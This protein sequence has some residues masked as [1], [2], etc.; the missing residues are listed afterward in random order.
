[1]SFCALAHAEPLA[2]SVSQ[3]NLPG[4]GQYGK[5][6]LFA[7]ALSNWLGSHGQSSQLIYYTYKPGMLHRPVTHAIV[8]W[9]RDGCWWAMGN[10]L[11]QPRL[12]GGGVG[13]EGMEIAQHYDARAYA[14]VLGKT[15]AVVAEYSPQKQIKT[16]ASVAQA[17]PPPVAQEPEVVTGMVSNGTWQDSKRFSLQATAGGGVVVSAHAPP[18]LN[19]KRFYTDQM[20]TEILIVQ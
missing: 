7:N 4:R 10:E 6:V 19:A 11:Q 8:A 1:M 16:A 12:L 3:L 17:A 15:K 18:K 20:G 14:A 13:D 5:C 9:E 2:D